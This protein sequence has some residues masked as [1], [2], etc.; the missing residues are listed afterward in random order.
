MTAARGAAGCPDSRTWR[1]R[2]RCRSG[3]LWERGARRPRSRRCVKTARSP[4]LVSGRPVPG[5]PASLGMEHA[6]DNP[7]AVSSMWKRQVARIGTTAAARS[8][9]GRHAPFLSN[10]DRPT[11]RRSPGRRLPVRIGPFLDR[12]A[13]DPGR[14]AALGAP[15]S[16]ENRPSTGARLETRARARTLEGGKTCRNSIVRTES[17]RS[18]PEVVD[19]AARRELGPIDALHELRAAHPIGEQ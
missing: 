5:P 3:A 7:W 14:P 1:R 11:E 18:E 16:T 17:W 4:L 13:F 12:M 2:P 10:S 8:S 6:L 9:G 19:G 15:K